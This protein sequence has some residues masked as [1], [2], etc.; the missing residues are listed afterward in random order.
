MSFFFFLKEYSEFHS[1]KI[2]H[3][4]WRLKRTKIRFGGISSIHTNKPLTCLVR[5]WDIMLPSLHTWEKEIQLLATKEDLVEVRIWPYG[6]RENW[7]LCWNTIKCQLSYKI[8]DMLWYISYE[9]STLYLM[10]NKSVVNGF[11]FIF[12]FFF[13][14][15]R[16]STLV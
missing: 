5:L 12:Y 7:R 8:L 11:F 2:S 3:D 9:T 16:I 6:D 15:N 10:Y 4:R 1:R 14:Q 13:L